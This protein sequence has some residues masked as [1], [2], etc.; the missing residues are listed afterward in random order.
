MSE[1]DKNE[2]G[3]GSGKFAALFQKWID[4]YEHDI[5]VFVDVLKGDLTPFPLKK[6]VATGLSY[7]IRQV[8]LVPD[9]YQPIGLIDDCIVL[10][11]VADLGAEWT[12]ELDPD[13]MKSMF[14]FANDC[15]MLKEYL[16]EFY[17]PLE[18]LIRDMGE[19]EV[20]RRTP[21]SIVESDEVLKSF[22]EELEEDVRHFK[23]V[24]IEDGPRAE[25]ELLSYFKA[26]LGGKK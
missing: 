6:L 20:H 8:D 13:H 14:K 1:E 17:R 4:H 21:E 24:A 3:V 18:N 10:R 22:L 26:K 2:E 16:G 7:Q 19:E 11:V 9:Y 25:R 5:E 23:A 12:A 15:D